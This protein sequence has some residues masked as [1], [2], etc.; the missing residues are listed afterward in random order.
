MKTTIFLALFI[1][2]PALGQYDPPA[3]PDPYQYQQ[4][5][6]P[7]NPYQYQPPI[8]PIQYQ[9]IPAPPPI[10][11]LWAPIRPVQPPV[12]QPIVPDYNVAPCSIWPRA[13]REVARGM[14][15]CK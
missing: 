1:A 15:A 10:P 6:Q 5:I 3:L 11:D 2:T 12:L 4:P 13:T 8:Q 9:P 14:G 7:I